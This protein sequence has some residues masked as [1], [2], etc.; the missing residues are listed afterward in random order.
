MMWLE[1]AI[2]IDTQNTVTHI[3]IVL[4]ICSG[5]ITVTFSGQDLNIVPITMVIDII[6]KIDNMDNSTTSMLVERYSIVSNLYW[7]ICNEIHLCL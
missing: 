5:G 4:T 2:K 6:D 7:R 1:G 3:I